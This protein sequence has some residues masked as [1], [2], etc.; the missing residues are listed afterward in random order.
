[1]GE[2]K[3]ASSKASN[4]RKQTQPTNKAAP[5][6]RRWTLEPGAS[7]DDRVAITS[8]SPGQPTANRS[9]PLVADERL[10]LR[11]STQR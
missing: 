1:M 7:R 10:G 11:S 6:T 4:S 2:A 9:P 8:R 5:A 3:R